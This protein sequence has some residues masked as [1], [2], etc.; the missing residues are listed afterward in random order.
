LA[1]FLLLAACGGSTRASE[2]LD[3]AS[4][5]GEDATTVG[6]VG[7]DAG[8]GGQ[9]ADASQ[10]G[11]TD[12]PS[13]DAGEEGG[14]DGQSADAAWEC[15][16]DDAQSADE[17]QDSG[18]CVPLDASTLTL[19]DLDTPCYGGATGRQLLGQIPAVNGSTFV[20]SGAPAGYKF[21]GSLT[22]TALTITFAYTGGPVQCNPPFP[23]DC[24]PPGPPDPCFRCPQCA[25]GHGQVVVP[26]DVIFQTADGAF[27]EHFEASANYLPG[28]GVN[29]QGNIPA[30]Q[31]HGTY[32]P[33]F[34]PGETFA[35]S[36]SV[37]GTNFDQ[38]VVS[39]MTSQ[40]SGGGGHWGP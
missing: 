12:G 15:G 26:L 19:P 23:P 32:P 1:P 8:E 38:G 6:N 2:P 28:G 14:T 39:E 18:I 30:S 25:V 33:I 11:A 3:A 37:L 9:D 4:D 35:F 27:N 21:S 22:P 13:A 29:W 5:A 34:S 36:G 10:D 7:R 17:G 20:P 31:L 24:D 16:V 40:I